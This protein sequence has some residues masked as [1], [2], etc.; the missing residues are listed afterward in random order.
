M[1]TDGIMSNQFPSFEAGVR[2]LWAPIV[3]VPISGSY[4]RLVIGVAVANESGFHVE[5]ANALDRLRCLY[6]DD[7]EG[8][9]YAIDLT[10]DHLRSDLGKRGVNAIVEPHPLLTG[11]EIGGSREAEGATL[12]AIATSWMHN[13]S[14]LYRDEAQLPA[15]FEAEDAQAQA[16]GVSDQLPALVMNYV[17]DRRDSFS[18]YFSSDLR[19]GRRRRL[20]GRSH[21]VLI[22][23]GG[24]RLVANFGTLRASGVA[25]SVNLI[26][27]RMWDLKVERDRV[28]NSAPVRQ[29]EMIVQSP[30][31][32]DPQVTERQQNLISDTLSAL[33]EQA[34]QEDLR[35]RP[36]SSVAE[37]GEH[38]L[39]VEMAQAVS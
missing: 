26:K 32:G 34:D 11:V 3:L 36:L 22:D 33:E 16:D 20:T 35:L 17:R 25:R 19:E 27:R 29:H 37:I 18:N 39:R 6:A 28:P 31:R 7:A 23:F 12:E 13:L 24:S 5:M 4:E 15:A 10:A 14:S 8:V 9:A 21:E 2:A 38:V 1:S 30:A